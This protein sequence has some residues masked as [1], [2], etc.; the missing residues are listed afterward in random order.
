MIDQMIYD[1]VD[2]DWEVFVGSKQIAKENTRESSRNA[3]LEVETV[4]EVRL[5]WSYFECD[6]CGKIFPYEGDMDLPRCLNQD[7]RSDHVQY[8]CGPKN[9]ES[10]EQ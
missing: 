2:D 10:E 6:E 3:A 5:A 7:C 4:T 8:L 1:H 9:T